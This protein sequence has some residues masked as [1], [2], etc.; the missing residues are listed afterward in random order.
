[1]PRNELLHRASRIRS[2]AS[3]KDA[4]VALREFA[5][6][7]DKGGARRPARDRHER[8]GHPD[9]VGSKDTSE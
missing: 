3:L 5:P 9:L 4:A 1:M 7:L 8:A 2:S 6:I